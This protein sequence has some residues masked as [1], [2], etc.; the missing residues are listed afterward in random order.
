MNPSLKFMIVG[1]SFD[2][3]VHSEFAST[4][5]NACLAAKRLATAYPGL[6][7]IIFRYGATFLK[8][9]ESTDPEAELIHSE[10]EIMKVVIP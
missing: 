8:S 5:N 3:I 10:D 2:Q 1:M 9:N 4:R 7:V 6:K